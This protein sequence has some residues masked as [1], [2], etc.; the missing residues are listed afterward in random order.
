MMLQVLVGTILVASKDYAAPRF[1]MFYGFVAFLTVGLAVPVPSP[2]AR[3][4]RDVLRARRPVPHGARHP[5]RAA[6][7]RDVKRR[8][9]R[10]AAVR[11]AL[12]R[13][14]R[15]AR[16]RGRGGR[17]RSTRTRYEVVPVAI[18]TDGRWLLADAAQRAHRRAP[19]CPTRSRRR[20]VATVDGRAGARPRSARARR[21]RR[22]PAAAR[23]LRRGRHRAGPARARRPAVRRLGRARLGGGD[24][25][26]D[27]EARVR[28]RR[29]A[30]RRR[31]VEFRD[32]D[33]RD[34]F[35]DAGRAR[36]RATRAS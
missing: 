9:R 19:R 24:G 8:Q 2:D 28:R 7:G 11:R 32:G 12:G 26:G 20:R 6:G 34:A 33:D 15:V 21:R 22:V 23:S 16:D 30:A 31:T 14:R 27:D 3:P 36:A 35:V 18:T 17:A 5:R 29:T 25:Q 4:P 13:A 1:H 10:A